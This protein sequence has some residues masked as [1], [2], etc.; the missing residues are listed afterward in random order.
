MIERSRLATLLL[1]LSLLLAFTARAEEPHL[2]YQ[3]GRGIADV[4][5][6]AFGIPMWGFGYPGQNTEG[7]HLR[8]KSRA[9][10]FDDGNARLVYV[11]ADI[12]S[13]EHNVTLE[14]IDRL[15]A[16]YGEQYS[17]GN[18]IISAT[19]TH[20]GPGGYWH[21]RGDDLG[22]AGSFYQEHFD[23]IVAGIVSSIRI[24]H[25]SLQPASI[26]IN[27]GEVEGA[28]V[29]RSEVAYL[30]NPA[31]ERARYKSN[32]NKQMTLLK[33]SGDKG[34]SRHGELVRCAPHLHDLSQPADLR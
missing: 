34:K 32:T 5:G 3:I 19:H 23:S 9:F 11:S 30:E 15:Q 24:A 29:N 31:D 33:F 18:V 28:G 14:I 22:L 27:T 1:V 4:T 16:M 20:A 13:I 6:P 2:N 21:T 7:I 10:V 17:L 8:L 12:G 25:E 26:L